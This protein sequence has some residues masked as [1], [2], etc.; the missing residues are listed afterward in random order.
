[1]ARFPKHARAGTC[2]AAVEDCVTLPCASPLKTAMRIGMYQWVGL[3]QVI[4]WKD[5]Q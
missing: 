2:D 4:M 1:M 5:V 3:E